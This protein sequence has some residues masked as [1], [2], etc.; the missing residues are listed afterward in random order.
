MIPRASRHP[1]AIPVS[2]QDAARSRIA[3]AQKYLKKS[4]A[5]LAYVGDGG[6]SEGDFY[7]G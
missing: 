6:T 1:M 4:V 3:F 2:T 5:V 7:E